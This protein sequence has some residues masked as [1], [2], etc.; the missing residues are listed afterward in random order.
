MLSPWAGLP[1]SA[2]NKSLV[3]LHNMDG[4]WKHS[5][6]IEA[7]VAALS[8]SLT[9][10]KEKIAQI[11]FNLRQNAALRDIEVKDLIGMRN[12]DMSRNTPAHLIEEQNII[13]R[14]RF[15]A[16]L[17]EKYEQLNSVEYKATLY[18]KKCGSAEVNW[19]QKQTRGADEAMTIFCT[20]A[21]C[22]HRWRM[23]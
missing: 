13:R 7:A 5:R 4:D 17:E 10:Y 23:S 20:C 6:E 1:P 2:R 21:T 19:E 18:C 14:K 22:H 16:M 3:L 15:E 9:S 11:A 8:D 12:E